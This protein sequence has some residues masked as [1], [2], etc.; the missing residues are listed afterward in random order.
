MKI[1]SSFRQAWKES[2]CGDKWGRVQAWRFAI[3]DA[4]TVKGYRPAHFRPSPFGPDDCEEYRLVKRYAVKTL[5]HLWGVLDRL[6]RLL[7]SQ[8]KDY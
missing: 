8:G 6:A 4:L 3:A 2:D 1:P 7:E 5:T